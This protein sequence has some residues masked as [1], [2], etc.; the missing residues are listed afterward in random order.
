MEIEIR[1][2]NENFEFDMR[3]LN[4]KH[5]EIKS[6]IKT[7]YPNQTNKKTSQRND[8]GSDVSTTSVFTRLSFPSPFRIIS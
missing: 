3:S 6:I 4:L 8:D 2:T 7:N 1:K 5:Q